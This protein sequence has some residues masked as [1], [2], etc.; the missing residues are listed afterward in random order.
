MVVDRLED[1]ATLLAL[2]RIR[3]GKRGWNDIAREVLADGSARAAWERLTD[4]GSLQPPTFESDLAAAREDLARWN[5]Q[6]VTFT[7]VLDEDYPTQLLDIV[8]T[9]PLLFYEG[10][11]DAHE[12]GVSVVGSRG[13]SP[14]GLAAARGAART[15]VKMGLTVISGLAA[16]ID[17]AAH[18]ETVALG[19]RTVAVVG[20]GIRRVYP[21]ANKP[22]ASS[23]VESGGL[24]LS[25]FLPDAPP[26]QSTFPMRNA[27]MSGYGIATFIAEAG[28]TSGS[29]IQARVAVE[30]GRPVI[31]NRSVVDAT[32]WAKRLVD[33]P[34]VHVVEGPDSFASAVS[35]IREENAE[36]QSVA[37]T[38]ALAFA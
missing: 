36:L 11:L 10:E 28:E 23:I 7:S 5:E 24:I 31:L 13:A 35:R 22:L 3:P 14:Q 4:D 33:K 16:G 30:H 1:R 6:G 18:S 8:Q 2:L 38:P 32:D 29:R 21:A 26:T 34:R 20:T 9:P 17:T 27:V 25:Q 19:G 12:S 15:L 37:S